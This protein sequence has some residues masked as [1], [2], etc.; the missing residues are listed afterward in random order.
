M[1]DTPILTGKPIIVVTVKCGHCGSLRTQICGFAVLGADERQDQ[2]DFKCWECNR[3]TRVFWLD[4]VKAQEAN[5]SGK[6]GE[7]G[8]GAQ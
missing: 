5:A 1:S 8:K 2:A 6:R 7:V 4:Y 3:M